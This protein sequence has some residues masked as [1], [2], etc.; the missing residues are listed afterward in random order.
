MKAPRRRRTP[1]EARTE[2]LD[3]ADRVLSANAPDAVG[4]AEVAQEAGVSLALVSHYFGTYVGLVDA[5]LERRRAGVRARIL[6]RFAE[7]DALDPDRMLEA[8][9]EALADRVFVRLSLWALAAERPS[10]STPFPVG[11]QGLRMLV[12]VFTARL[13][14]R[15][16][17]TRRRIERALVITGSAAWGY[18]VA[19]EGWIGALG[20]TPSPSFD[21]GIREALGEMLRGYMA[22]VLERAA[23]RG[24]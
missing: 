19:R 13:G 21:R 6:A 7:S 3:A 1:E 17:A 10:A 11:A 15:S 20:H 14:D 5:V 24:V 8:L 4:L 12:D 16:A 18:V 9:L 2:I 23:R 22:P